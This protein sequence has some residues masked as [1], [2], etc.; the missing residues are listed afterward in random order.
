MV[1]AMVYRDSSE[2]SAR[3]GGAAER[4]RARLR[5]AA[6]KRRT[7][8]IQRAAPK[9]LNPYGSDESDAEDDEGAGAPDLRAP[10][11]CLSSC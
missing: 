8:A 6:K 10:H 2:R 5:A 11:S 9:A 7:A 4:R 1:A 3:A